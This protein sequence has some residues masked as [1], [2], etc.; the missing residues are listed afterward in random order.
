MIRESALIPPEESL[1]VPKQ[2]VGAFFGGVRPGLLAE[3]LPLFSGARSFVALW[4]V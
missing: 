4:E 2:R 3:Q 1:R